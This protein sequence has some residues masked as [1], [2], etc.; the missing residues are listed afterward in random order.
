M[1]RTLTKAE[2]LEELKALRAQVTQLETL[3]AELDHTR[4]AGRRAAADLEA[5]NEH[6]RQLVSLDPLTHVL[7]RKGLLQALDAELRQTRRTGSHPIAILLD[8][9]HFKQINRRFGHTVGDA[10]LVEIARRIQSAL[11][12]SDYVA[13]IGTDEFLTILPETGYWEA[14]RIAERI[15]SKVNAPLELGVPDPITVAASL[16]VCAIPDVALSL[17][18]VLE[19]AQT[20]LAKSKAVQ[21]LAEPA[22]GAGE[23]GGVTG[24]LD[25]LSA[26]GTYRAVREPIVHLDSGSV[27]GYEILARTT[28]PGFERPG[29]FLPVALA[30]NILTV[31]DLHCLKVCLGL[32]AASLEVIDYHVNL[33]PST[34]LTTPPERLL[35]AFGEDVRKRL[36]VEVTEQ[37]FFGD[38]K[39]LRQQM[40]VLRDAGI[41]IALDD[42][43]FGRTSLELL[44]LLAPDVVKI[45]QRFVKGV[46]KDALQASAFRRLMD[47]I[48]TL[49]ATA[50]AEG[51]ETP[52]DREA[53]QAFG[54]PYAQG[55]LWPGST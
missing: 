10:V 6:L 24:L 37:Q 35:E 4:E 54:V 5:S 13:R 45:D 12:T 7:N 46:S 9:D 34:I 25:L 55:Y 40:A 17:E 21:H 49:G 27:A 31:A 53:I 18:Q 38:S 39:S 22:G 23:G 47:V 1:K 15:R 2:L 3:R 11:R 43:G 44:I 48:G 8:C 41:R 26:E 36:C 42:V 30:H 29:D 16:G 14:V 28:I 51:I 19:L 20:T 50:I 52:E 32:V 33:F